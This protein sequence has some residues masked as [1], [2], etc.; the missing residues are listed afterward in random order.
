MEKSE[1][2]RAV[3]VRVFNNRLVSASGRS[4]EQRNNKGFIRK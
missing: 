1:I 4:E 3:F 2:V